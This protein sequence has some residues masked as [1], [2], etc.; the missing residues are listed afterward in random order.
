VSPAY[1]VFAVMRN[2]FAVRYSVF[3]VSYNVF[4][5]YIITYCAIVRYNALAATSRVLKAG[6]CVRAC[7]RACVVWSCPVVM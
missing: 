5:H 3:A 6:V 2:V 7:V 1:S 4:A